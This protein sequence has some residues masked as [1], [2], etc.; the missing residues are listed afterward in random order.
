MTLSRRFGA[1]LFMNGR[2][3]VV[4][5][6]TDKFLIASQRFPRGRPAAKIRK[7]RKSKGFRRSEFGRRNL[8]LADTPN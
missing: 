2:A 4:V 3:M 1:E 8:Q 6:Y 7:Y 5:I